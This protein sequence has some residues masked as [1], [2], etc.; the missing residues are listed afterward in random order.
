LDSVGRHL[1][2]ICRSPNVPLGFALACG[3]VA[4]IRRQRA[5]G[6]WLFYFFCQVL[7]GMAMVTASTHW[8]NYSPGEWSSPRRYFPFTLFNL[9]RVLLLA[10]IAVIGILLVETREWHWVI[11]LQYALAT[12][13]CLTILKLPVDSYCFPS[14]TRRDAMS[15]AFP[16]LWTGYFAV[17]RRVRKVFLERSWG[18]V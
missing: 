13:A 1:E 17:S 6:G 11:A 2:H 4:I 5:I 9:S 8:K 15:L 10:A 18:R 3:I 7:L 14:A 12:Y 16:V